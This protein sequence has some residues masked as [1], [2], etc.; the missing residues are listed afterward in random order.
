MRLGRLSEA[1]EQLRLSQS[2]P[3]T[4]EQRIKRALKE[5]SLLFSLGETEAYERT[6]RIAKS[7]DSELFGV[8]RQRMALDG[9][10]GLGVS[11]NMGDR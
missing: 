3:K 7:Y 5:A 4:V 8:L 1:L 9:H 11:T 6:L 10:P 2:L